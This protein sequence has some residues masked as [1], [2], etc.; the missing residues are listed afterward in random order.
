MSTINFIF[1]ARIEYFG[2]LNVLDV[3]WNDYF[4]DAKVYSNSFLA[5]QS[6]S[7]QVLPNTSLY[8]DGKMGLGHQTGQEIWRSN[9]DEEVYTHSFRLLNVETNQSPY[10]WYN[11]GLATEDNFHFADPN[12]NN[13][14]SLHL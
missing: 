7:L 6:Q 4:N 11:L 13:L 5:S 9:Y 14:D 12:N 2:N 3:G 8:L 10:V 1:M